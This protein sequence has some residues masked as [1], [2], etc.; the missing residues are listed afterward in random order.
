[1]MVVKVCVG[2]SCHLKGASRIVELLQEKIAEEKLESE[3]ILSGSFCT[4]KCNRIGVTITIGDDV[5]NG[6][7][8]EEF[9]DFW[10]NSIL[11]AVNDAKKV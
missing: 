6:I 10:K 9:S 11:P 7:I 3:I 1:M 2:S 5:H 8:P 4:G